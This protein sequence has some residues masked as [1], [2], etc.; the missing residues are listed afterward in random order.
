MT[1]LFLQS[2][3][4]TTRLALS[5]RKLKMPSAEEIRSMS[6]RVSAA[7]S[8]ECSAKTKEGVRDVF[9]AAARAALAK[10][11]HGYHNCCGC[12]TL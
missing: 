7:A 12:N 4:E 8:V 11:F 10:P 9:E 1:D 6:D 5:A 2:Q 3:D